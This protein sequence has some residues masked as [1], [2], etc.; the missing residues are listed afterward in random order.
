[1]GESPWGEP[2]VMR[3]EETQILGWLVQRKERAENSI[4]CLPGTHTKWAFMQGDTLQQFSTAFS[5][6][7]FALLSE[8]SMLVRGEQHFSR[9]DF[10]RGVERSASGDALNH[11]LFSVRSR[12]LTG[13]LVADHAESY[14]SGLIIGAEIAG[15]RE[16][17]ADN[18]PVD[19]I[20]NAELAC[21]YR[22]ALEY[23][24]IA[25]RKHEGTALSFAGLFH[26]A[27]NLMG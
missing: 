22:A 13:Q 4:L 16:H 17:L 12:V 1:M 5:G 7:L 26:L 6:E 23:H 2:D 20:G 3:G 15:F 24:G 27:K 14:L 10:L 25:C 11:I 19:I 18:I 21:A 8:A 9:E